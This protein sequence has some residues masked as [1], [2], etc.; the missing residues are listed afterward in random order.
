MM[1]AMN[2]PARHLL[3]GI[4]CVVVVVIGVGWYFM[5]DPRAEVV[6]GPAD[7]SGEVHT[8]EFE[9]VRVDIPASWERLDMGDCEFNFEHWGPPEVPPCDPDAQGVA[10]YGS[11][12]FDPD[13]GP[14]V[15]KNDE[16]D[17][18]APDWEGYAYAGEFA[19][20]ASADDRGVV[21]DILKSAR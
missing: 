19:V 9:G 15:I 11:S 14:G 7:S 8:I 5:Q 12:T 21:Q 1:T 3:W 20:Y 16:Q 18:E 4:L 6:D 10:F 2:R 17:P 13:L